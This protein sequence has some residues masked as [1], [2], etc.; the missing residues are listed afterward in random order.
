MNRYGVLSQVLPY[1][2]HLSSADLTIP[3]LYSRMWVEKING[4]HDAYAFIWLL[5]NT[6]K[7]VT[8]HAFF[9]SL[10][11]IKDQ[12]VF[13]SKI[14]KFEENAKVDAKTLQKKRSEFFDS[15]GPVLFLIF[16]FWPFL[17][18]VYFSLYLSMVIAMIAYS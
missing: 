8:S 6:E 5:E 1:Q 13:G 14:V 12:I 11:S 2:F 15:R 7:V 16:I 3:F 9:K 17:W 10:G 4:T 18:S